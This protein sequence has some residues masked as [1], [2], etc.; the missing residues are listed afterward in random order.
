[1]PHLITSRRRP[2]SIIILF[3]IFSSSCKSSGEPGA[4][5]HNAVVYTVN[6]NFETVQAF[7]AKDGKS[8][9]SRTN[10]EIL[11]RNEAKERIDANEHLFTR[12]IDTHADFSRY[13]QQLFMGN[14]FDEANWEAVVARVKSLRK[15]I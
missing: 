9:A 8:I 1:M 10:E 14:L 13:D 5:V 4:I 6:E 12:F 15:S 2:L 3:S 7:A 11:N